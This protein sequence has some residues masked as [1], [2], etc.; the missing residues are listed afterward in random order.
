MCKYVDVKGSAAMLAVKTAKGSAG[1]TQEVNL[2]NP[3]N[4]IFLV[5]EFVTGCVD[6]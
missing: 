1:V 6:K 2:R 4:I 3:K 5:R